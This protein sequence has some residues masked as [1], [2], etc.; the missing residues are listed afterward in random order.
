MP[1]PHSTRPCVSVAQVSFDANPDDTVAEESAAERPA[2]SAADVAGRKRRLQAAVLRPSAAQ[3]GVNIAEGTAVVNFLLPPLSRAGGGAAGA[4]PEES[5]LLPVRDYHMTMERADAARGDEHYALFWDDA[6]A[7]V[8][9]APIRSRAM[10]TSLKMHGG[11]A[12]AAVA[13]GSDAALAARVRRRP[14]TEEE[15]SLLRRTRAGVNVLAP[16]ARAAAAVGA[17]TGRRPGAAAAT[18]LYDRLRAEE[19]PT[20]FEPRH[21]EAEMSD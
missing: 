4:A 11:V 12:A 17:A 3:Q 14:L 5:L 2:A 9:L 16:A 8:L 21:D 7:A 13:A 18:S 15:E 19:G 6:S 10:L 20:N 1:R